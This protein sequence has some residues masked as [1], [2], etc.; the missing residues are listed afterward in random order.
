MCLFHLPTP[1]PR[2]NKKA[3]K[4]AATK[5]FDS[6]IVEDGAM[7]QAYYSTPYGAAPTYNAYPSYHHPYGTEH[8]APEDEPFYI[9]KRHWASHEDAAR[10]M[11]AA[12]K[13]NGKKAD[14]MKA[15]LSGGATEARDVA[16][17]IQSAI[18]NSHDAIGD[19]HTTVKDVHSSLKETYDAIKKNHSEHINK[20]DGCAAEISKVRTMMEEEA[21]KREEAHKRQQNMQEAWNYFQ[22]FRQAERDAETKSSG[23][24]THRRSSSGS[25]NSN[26]P[27]RRRTEAEDAYE[28][29]RRRHR[30]RDV[31]RSVWEYMNQLFGDRDGDR[32]RDRTERTTHENHNHFYP[33]ASP[34]PPW[35]GQYHADTRG[36]W[37]QYPPFQGEDD[38]Y[39]DFDDGFRYGRGPPRRPYNHPSMH[40]AARGTRAPRYPPRFI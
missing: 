24:S 9:T 1:K 27:R 34:S 6:G 26:T 22:A 28:A 25:R 33:H 23:S 19:I 3:K 21:K 29:E 2:K 38:V 35:N 14:E 30:D 40:N 36:D 18:K 32:D 4:S 31:R 7:N 13:E 12:V 37:Q 16:N 39:E 15:S 20:Q 11:L 17:N 8:R 5:A 10:N